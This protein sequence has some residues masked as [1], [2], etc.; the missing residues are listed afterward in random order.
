MAQLPEFTHPLVSDEV[1]KGE[2]AVVEQQQDIVVVQ[3]FKGGVKDQ[4]E[5]VTHSA[6]L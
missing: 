6:I 3:V 5:S 4:R 1:V 2:A